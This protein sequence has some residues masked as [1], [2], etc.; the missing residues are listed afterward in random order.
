VQG[1]AEGT[2]DRLLKRLAKINLLI[3]IHR[4]LAVPSFS[5]TSTLRHSLLLCR[6]R[7]V[8]ASAS[9]IGIS[10]SVLKDIPPGPRA[11]TADCQVKLAPC[12]SP[13]SRHHVICLYFRLN[14]SKSARAS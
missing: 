3:D 7:S 5:R 11:Q 1:R 8:T 2:Y 13:C 12:R 4:E 9:E 6:W 14:R 10:H